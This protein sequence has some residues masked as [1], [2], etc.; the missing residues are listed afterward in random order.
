MTEKFLNFHGTYIGRKQPFERFFL[1]NVCSEWLVFS[2]STHFYQFEL[3][4]H[5]IFIV[6]FLGVVTATGSFKGK[7]Q[8]LYLSNRADLR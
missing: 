5:W 7:Y 6:I 3:Y 4:L 1:K 2:G 8:N